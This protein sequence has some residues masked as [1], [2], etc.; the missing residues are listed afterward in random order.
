MPSSTSDVLAGWLG[1]FGHGGRNLADENR[2]NNPSNMS[3][4]NANDGNDVDAHENI[5]LYNDI[6]AVAQMRKLKGSSKGYYASTDDYYY[7]GGT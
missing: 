5:D 1:I 7:S 2:E 4:N 6:K 3:E